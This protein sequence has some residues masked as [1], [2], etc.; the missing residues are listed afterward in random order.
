MNRLKNIL[1][2]IWVIFWALKFR[3]AGRN[4]YAPKDKAEGEFNYEGE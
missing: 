1:A 3:W 2:T 4:D